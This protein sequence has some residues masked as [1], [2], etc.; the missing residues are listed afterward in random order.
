MFRL[1]LVFKVLRMNFLF[2]KKKSASLEVLPARPKLTQNSLT[3]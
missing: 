1:A 3:G 2:Q